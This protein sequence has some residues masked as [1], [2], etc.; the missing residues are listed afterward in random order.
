MSR[1]RRDARLR[2]AKHV[3]ASLLAV[4]DL[5]GGGRVP[6]HRGVIQGDGAGD[7]TDPPAVCDG[8]CE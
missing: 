5:H 7:A 8:H 6:A 3:A 4:G 2:M 1:A